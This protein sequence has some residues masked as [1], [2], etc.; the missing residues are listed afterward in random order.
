MLDKSKVPARPAPQR[1]SP[2][3]P[4]GAAVRPVPTS[5]AAAW[6][7]LP[8]GSTTRPAAQAPGQAL[9]RRGSDRAEARCLRQ[10]TSGPLSGRT[11]AAIRARLGALAGPHT[12]PARRFRGA[13]QD[14]RT[15]RIQAAKN[16]H[17]EA[18][19]LVLGLGA[20]VTAAGLV[21]ARRKIGRAHV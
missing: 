21:R 14:G 15:G 5:A 9:A 16:G 19:R 6:A 1:S 12:S 7:Y 3:P 2:R 4:P 8:L 10:G 17:E 18:V 20:D 11:P 13:R